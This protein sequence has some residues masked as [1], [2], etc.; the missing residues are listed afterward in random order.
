MYIKTKI[1]FVSEAK[2]EY[3]FTPTMSYSCMYISWLCHTK[4]PTKVVLSY[5]VAGFHITAPFLSIQVDEYGSRP[6]WCMWW[7]LAEAAMSHHDLDS[8]SATE[9]RCPSNGCVGSWPTSSH[10]TPQ[11]VQLWHWY[12]AGEGCK[13]RWTSLPSPFHSGSMASST[14]QV[15]PTQDPL[16]PNFK[17]QSEFRRI[18]NSVWN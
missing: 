1:P 15:P 18:L 13:N 4:S 6:R 5:E 8:A 14:C 11:N 12:H 2:E 9:W 3:L 7:N 17:F 16:A 10:L